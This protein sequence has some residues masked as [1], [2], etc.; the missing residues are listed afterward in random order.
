MYSF[1]SKGGESR[2]A[3]R[4]PGEDEMSNKTSVVSPAAGPPTHGHKD[5]L[6]EEELANPGSAT[7]YN[8]NTAETREVVIKY[9]N[10]SEEMKNSGGGMGAIRRHGGTTLVVCG[11]Q[12]RDFKKIRLLLAAEGIF[13]P[14][15]THLKRCGFI[16]TE[17]YHKDDWKSP[18]G[19]MV[20]GKTWFLK[21]I[22]PI[23][24]ASYGPKDHAGD[25]EEA[26]TKIE[27]YPGQK[28]SWGGSP[29]PG[30]DTRAFSTSTWPAG[31][32]MAVRSRARS[33]RRQR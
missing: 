18:S 32:Q 20:E 29:G 7:T 13:V 6:A 31:V 1:M 27:K 14:D 2:G 9:I 8:P 30:G 15:M 11:D 5:K 3:G 24:Q 25:L 33:T 22:A 28:R 10:E 26:W 17:H 21:V 19:R 23:S 16:T 12:R 4:L